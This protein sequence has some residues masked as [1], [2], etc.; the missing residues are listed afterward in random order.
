[1]EARRDGPGG[2]GNTLSLPPKRKS[3]STR[4]LQ[5]KVNALEEQ[6]EQVKTN[7]ENVVSLL[8]RLAPTSGSNTGVTSTQA[9]SDC[10]TPPGIPPS[11]ASE[12]STS[13][14]SLE[15]WVQQIANQQLHH[16]PQH[17]AQRSLI[18][19]PH[20]DNL[21]P[22]ME[23]SE[24]SSSTEGEG[25]GDGGKENPEGQVEGMSMMR[26]MLRREE[27][28]RL[29]ADG[30]LPAESLS[31]KNPTNLQTHTHGQHHQHQPVG[32]GQSGGQDY[33]AGS[34]SH[35]QTKK[36]KR[37]TNSQIDHSPTPKLLDPVAEGICDE[38]YG[39]QLFELFFRGAH[40]F[41]PVYDP[42]IDTWDSLRR[43]SSF[44]VSV[45]LFVGQ[46]IMDA[47]NEASDL[48]RRLKEHAENIGKSTLFSPIANA[49]ALQAMIVLA[50]WG[51]TGWRPGSH[52]IS[53]AIDMEL[54]RC[55]PRLAE[56][57]YSEKDHQTSSIVADAER[58]LVIG[59]RLWLTVCKMAIE[60]AYNHGRPLIIDENLILPHA[61]ALLSHPNRLPTDGRI[62]ASCEI[63]LH[64]L[65]LHRISLSDEKGD[66]DQA[67]HRF[68]DGAH[69]WEAK[70]KEYYI[71]QGVS[72]D[73]I[74][75]TDLTTQRCFSSVLANSYLLRDIR[76]PS[77]VGNLPP[78]RRQWLLSSLD[79]AR[80]IAGRILS[81]EK[82]KLIYANHYSHVALAS[83]SRIY[84]RLATLFPEAIDLRK[85]AKDL[86]QLTDVL[87][88]FPGFSFAR[89]LKYVITKARKKRILP[90]ETRP[91]SPRAS[92]DRQ[93]VHV[94]IGQRSEPDAQGQ[95]SHTSGQGQ[96]IQQT[97]LSMDVQSLFDHP[98]DSMTNTNTNTNESPLEFDPFIAEELFNQSIANLGPVDQIFNF[99]FN[100]D[101][102]AGE[103]SVDNNTHLEPIDQR[104]QYQHDNRMANQNN[105]QL[106]WLSTS[107]GTNPIGSGGVSSN[108][109]NAQ[110]ININSNALSWLDFPALGMSYFGSSIFSQ[111][112]M[113][114]CTVCG[115]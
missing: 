39:R 30:H 87:A 51:D 105:E 18:P 99:G 24:S 14:P 107:D 98:S 7:L 109:A 57:Q 101:M 41:I 8:L 102:T 36:R 13:T 3:R 65:P 108:M 20:D 97:M 45:I 75:V 68:N 110:N 54:Y 44:S 81:T 83:V 84:I 4:G 96:Q 74:L 46:K 89:Q 48:Q 21:E 71:H 38:I 93:P 10:R 25:A 49:E 40:A 73:D 23:H 6:M 90:P 113:L 43:R 27:R 69:T 115:A 55:L 32:D 94:D 63:L 2:S 66:V 59:A 100:F 37:S 56:R 50:S 80:F 42:A 82:N 72:T 15:Q 92:H 70:W 76:S 1:M 86:T 22:I 103:N 53:M 29:R 95:Y 60:M 67:L 78:H 5:N 11:A 62:I 111:P 106:F 85:V 31:P 28:K 114:V 77:D 64:R 33:D 58:R 12:P 91:G 26:D 88:H 112:L 34:Q 52:A 104:N 79:D 17:T 47:G 19:L 35:L 61:H 9:A 16:T